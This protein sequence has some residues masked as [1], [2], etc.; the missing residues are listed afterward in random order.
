MHLCLSLLKR[1]YAKALKLNRKL[2]K[3]VNSM[4]QHGFGMGKLTE[5]KPATL[6]EKERIAKCISN[7]D[8]IVWAH[9]VHKSY[10]IE[11]ETLKL[12]EDKESRWD[13][14]WEIKHPPP[15]VKLADIVACARQHGRDFDEISLIK[16]HDRSWYRGNPGTHPA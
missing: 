6:A 14:I 7:I 9:V 12:R 16:V 11:K 2:H 8:G 15:P 1:A 10:S 5:S 3:W 13:I 4:T